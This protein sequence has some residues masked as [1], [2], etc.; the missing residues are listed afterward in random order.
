MCPCRGYWSLPLPL[1]LLCLLSSHHMV[2]TMWSIHNPSSDTLACYRTTNNTANQSWIYTSASVNLNKIFPLLSLAFCH[3][4]E[5]LAVLVTFSHSWGWI[6][7]RKKSFE[8]NDFILAHGSGDSPS[9]Q[10]GLVQTGS[11]EKFATALTVLSRSRSRELGPRVGLG[12]E[13]KDRPK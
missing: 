6:F 3:S 12:Y 13:P 2:I 7:Y 9:W 10:N 4:N 5:K 8:R 1:S 11:L